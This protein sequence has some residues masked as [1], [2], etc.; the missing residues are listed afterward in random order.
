MSPQEVPSEKILACMAS[1]FGKPVTEDQVNMTWAYRIER[2]EYIPQHCKIIATYTS[3]LKPHLDIRVIDAPDYYPEVWN[4]LL[5][6]KLI[7]DEEGHDLTLVYEI[8]RR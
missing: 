1:L 8:K 3:Q 6:L 5:Q 2:T 7:A 4:Q